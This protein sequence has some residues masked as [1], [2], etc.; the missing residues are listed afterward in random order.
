MPES[1]PAKVKGHGRTLAARRERA[2]EVI[3]RLRSRYPDAKCG[4]DFSTP[5]ELLVA[6]ILSAQCTDAMVNSVTPELFRR[7]PVPSGAA[8][9]GLHELQSI[10]KPCGYYRQ[11]SRFVRDACSMLMDRY[12]GKVPKSIGELTTLPGVARK[13]ANV[14]LSVAF[15]IN[16]GVAVDTHVAR[17]SIRLGLSA[18]RTPQHIEA[19]LMKTVGRDEWGD[20]TTLLIA[21]GRAV[22]GARKPLCP[23][24]V[25]NSICPSAYKAKAGK[26]QRR[27]AKG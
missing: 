18:A 10:V 27:Q 5:E 1:P 4:L 6:T 26:A 24:C 9:A 3:A 13:T 17:L 25:L 15:G 11:K 22:C 14:V 21:H 20:L 8:S 16:E 2:S 23:E 19:D 7:Y 12:G